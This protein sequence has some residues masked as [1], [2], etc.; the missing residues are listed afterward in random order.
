MSYRHDHYH[1]YEHSGEYY[2]GMLI[3]I[4]VLFCIIGVC[5]TYVAI[6]P[7]IFLFLL[8]ILNNRA[9]KTPDRSLQDMFKAH[10]VVFVVG[11]I[12]C[13]V[14]LVNWCAK[15]CVNSL[16]KTS[17]L[18]DEELVKTTY[19]TLC[20]NTYEYSRSVLLVIGFVLT[21]MVVEAYVRAR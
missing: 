4:L 11:A 1:Y 14:A 19:Y 9:D 20:R 5:W 10:T 3:C 8:Y 18:P 17:T 13:V 16:A 6:V 21:V 12:D 2:I 15:G 7:P